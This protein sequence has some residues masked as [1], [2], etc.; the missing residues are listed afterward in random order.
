MNDLA[1]KRPKTYKQYMKVDE[2]KSR[3]QWTRAAVLPSAVVAAAGRVKIE[4]A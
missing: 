2:Y 3:A 4:I 1:L